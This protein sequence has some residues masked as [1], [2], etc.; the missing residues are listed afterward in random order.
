MT[1]HGPISVL[2]CGDQAK[3]ALVTYPDV[4]LNCKSVAVFSYTS[5]TT[6]SE[7]EKYG[8]ALCCVFDGWR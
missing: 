8:F 5:S 1:T 6:V 7:F 2:V 4:G 3:P